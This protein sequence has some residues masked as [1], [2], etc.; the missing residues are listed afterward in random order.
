MKRIRT[1]IAMIRQLG[2][3]NHSIG[4][5]L[6]KASIFMEYD[7]IIALCLPAK[8]QIRPILY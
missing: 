4:F 3:V 7:F 5:L 1:I 2:P 6:E 8:H